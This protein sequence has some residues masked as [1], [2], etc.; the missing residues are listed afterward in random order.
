[1]RASVA[2]ADGTTYL[3]DGQWGLSEPYGVPEQNELNRPGEGEIARAQANLATAKIARHVWEV[4]VG[5][6]A[7]GKSSAVAI[8]P[9]GEQLD[10]ALL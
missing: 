2:D 7:G 3:G 10:A 9:Q 6:G 5:V 4:R 1:M 8:S